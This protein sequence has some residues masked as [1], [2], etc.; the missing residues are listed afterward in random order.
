M[1]TVA[2]PRHRLALTAIV[3]G[4]LSAVVLGFA[5]ATPVIL[6]PRDLTWTIWLTFVAGQA[7]LVSAAAFHVRHPDAWRS[8]RTI[9]LAFVGL[10][11]ASLT[12][13]TAGLLEALGDLSQ[14]YAQIQTGFTLDSLALVPL[15]VGSALLWIGLRAARRQPSAARRSRLVR[16]I[17]VVVGIELALLLVLAVAVT[18]GAGWTGLW[19]GLEFVIV[20]GAIVTIAGLLATTLIGGGGAGERPAA[21]WWIGGIGWAI[22]IVSLPVA[23]AVTGAYPLSLMATGTCIFVAFALGLPEVEPSTAEVVERAPMS[24]G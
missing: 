14:S 7:P 9:A 13:A 22:Q 20:G 4:V 12:S 8:S 6:R 16:A 3:Y 15:E 17:W 24:V 23:I 19:L 10:A 5:I 1:D 18:I 21:G 11:A 2:R